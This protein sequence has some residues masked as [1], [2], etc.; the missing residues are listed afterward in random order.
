M[1]SK[2]YIIC[3]CFVVFTVLGDNTIISPVWGT[4]I[5]TNQELAVK[6]KPSSTNPVDILLR[7]GSPQNL[8]TKLVIG[9]GIPNSG[10]FAWLVPEHVST[11]TDYAI[12]IQDTITKRSNFSPYF[13]VLS[14]PHAALNAP[15]KDEQDTATATE[16]NSIDPSVLQAAGYLY[17]QPLPSAAL[18]A[19]SAAVDGEQ[20]I[21]QNFAKPSATPTSSAASSGIDTTAFTSSTS[22]GE[23]LA[24]RSTNSMS[25]QSISKGAHGFTATTFP[26]SAHQ[27]ITTTSSEPTYATNQSVSTATSSTASETDQKSDGDRLESSLVVLLSVSLAILFGLI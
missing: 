6:W 3:L 9:S 15:K 1:L 7:E 11:N 5:S 2:K 19:P 10:S 17:G 24:V 20:I 21:E 27:S 26:S 25:H 4:I 14:G 8:E 18:F 23:S 13:T 16:S 22:L 12:E